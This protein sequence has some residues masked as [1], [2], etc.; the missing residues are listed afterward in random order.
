[1]ML[2]QIFLFIILNLLI[3]GYFFM[4]WLFLLYIVFFNIVLNL[5]VLGNA[6]SCSF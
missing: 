2:R 1:M 5:L 6:L 4:M 3:I